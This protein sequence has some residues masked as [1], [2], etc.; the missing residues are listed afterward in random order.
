LVAVLFDLEGTLTG[1]GYQ[2][3][4]AEVRSRMRERLIELG[5]PAGELAGLHNSLTLMLN[6]AF[7][8]VSK[9][10]TADEFKLFRGKVSELLEQYWVRS[11][12]ESFLMPGALEALEAIRAAGYSLGLVSNASRLD[13][14]IALEKHGLSR[15]F[16][17]VVSSDEMSLLK[18][19]PE[20]V[21]KALRQ[22]GEVDFVLVGD[23]V[24]DL[25]A[26]RRAG[27]RAVIVQPDPGGKRDWQPDAEMVHGS[28]ACLVH[29]LL[30]VPE[31]VKRLLPLSPDA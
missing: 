10:A 19:E 7:S 8:Y 11:A 1:S 13:V 18:P 15:F 30:E 14:G 31:I 26:A 27:G 16:D 12:R 2:F 24:Y 4:A 25:E 17:A 22:L 29:S 5:V 28:G 3:S 6:K 9:T 23:S 20:G 21:F